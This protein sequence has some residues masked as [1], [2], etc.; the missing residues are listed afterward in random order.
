MLKTWILAAVV[1]GASTRAMAQSPAPNPELVSASPA[2][3]LR[4]PGCFGTRGAWWPRMSN[5]GERP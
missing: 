3:R 2:L 4:I 5:A 1:V